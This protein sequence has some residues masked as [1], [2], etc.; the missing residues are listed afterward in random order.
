M[1]VIRVSHTSAKYAH[2]YL[3]AARATEYDT[4]ILGGAK[5]ARLELGFSRHSD[6]DQ[7]RHLEPSARE[8][9]RAIKA[10]E[11]EPPPL[12]APRDTDEPST[13]DKAAHF[14]HVPSF[15]LIQARGVYRLQ[16]RVVVR[17]KAAKL[18]QRGALVHFVRQW[19]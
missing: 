16:R 14:A 18:R 8:E 7:A 11:R 1:A 6:Q 4:A 15:Q 9:V 10:C 2:V 3:V 17:E 5:D 13:R 12:D 19:Y